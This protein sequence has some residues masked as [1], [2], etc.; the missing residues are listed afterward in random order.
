[1]AYKLLYIEDLHPESIISDLNS[2]GIKVVPLNPSKFEDV[3]EI[4]VK[5]DYNAILIDFR[6]TSGTGKAVFDAPTVAQTQR[7]K[8]STEG[9]HKPIFLISTEK[10]ISAYYKDFTSN[11]LFDL[12]I[13]KEVFQKDLTKY[14]QIF[15]SFID[16]YSTIEKSKF[17]LVDILKTNE[18]LY[19]NLDYRIEESLNNHLFKSNTYKISKFIYKN[20]IKSIG[21][22]IGE[23]VLAARLGVSIKSEGW[24]NL[25]K[26]FDDASYKG[27]YSVPY[28]R[29]W[30]IEVER[31]CLERLGINSL[32]RLK[33]NQRIELLNKA[34]LNNLLP[35]D[36]LEFTESTNYWTICKH[37]KVPLDPIDGLELFQREIIPWQ[38]KQ[39]ISMLAALRSSDYLEDVKAPDKKRFKEFTETL[40]K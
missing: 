1:M 25:K 24:E 28:N 38:E 4:I 3:F 39:Y 35:I 30:A 18:A 12:S 26:I 13:S 32:R 5:G 15:I 16:A 11:D 40:E 21:V 9:I 33:A 37:F 31:I 20:I 23:D 17:K 27:I 22:L 10:N 8:N 34:G 29:W 36:K 19:S 6:L 14:C 2:Q 7:T